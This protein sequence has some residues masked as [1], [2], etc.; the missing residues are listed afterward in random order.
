M[1]QRE[2]HAGHAR[3]TD[4]TSEIS[5]H[6]RVRGDI[7]VGRGLRLAGVVRGAV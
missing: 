7:Y 6:E 3:N 5:A 4:I 1:A 2:R